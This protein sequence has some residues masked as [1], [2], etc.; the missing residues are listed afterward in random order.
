M[1][2][3]SLS[4]IETFLK[5]A[6]LVAGGAF[7][8]WKL[9]TGWLIANVKLSVTGSREAKDDQTD[10][11]AIAV[12]VEKGST[13]SVWLK[14]ASVRVT[15]MGE[16]PCAPIDLTGFQRLNRTGDKLN[17]EVASTGERFA[18]SPGETLQLAAISTV[19]AGK[20]ALLEAAIFA[21]RPLWQFQWRATSVSLP[22]SKSCP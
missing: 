15:P 20:P 3:S 21:T 12:N 22:R 4:N 7:F 8:A 19:P 17:W 9:W 13:D 5:I 14:H 1:N 6:A 2:C 16:A 18:V 10:F 11:I